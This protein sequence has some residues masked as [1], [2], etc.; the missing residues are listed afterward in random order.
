MPLPPQVFVPVYDVGLAQHMADQLWGGA[1]PGGR[2]GGSFQLATDLALAVTLLE[3]LGE[4][5]EPPCE[6]E[7]RRHQATQLPRLTRSS[8]APAGPSWPQPC[9]YTRTAHTQ[10]ARTHARAHTRT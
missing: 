5:G 6:P 10:D 1:A 3:M 4:G 9:L 7:L 2:D 8:R